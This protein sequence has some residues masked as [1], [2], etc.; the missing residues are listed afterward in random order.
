M[1][2]AVSFVLLAA[3]GASTSRESAPSNTRSADQPTTAKQIFDIRTFVN[4]Q[5]GA[6]RSVWI[7]TSRVESVDTNDPCCG[8]AYDGDKYNDKLASCAIKDDECAPGFAPVY[9]GI[10]DD[11][12]CGERRRCVPL[13]AVRV[14]VAD[15]TPVTALDAVEEE[16]PVGGPD[17]AHRQ[18]EIGRE[19]FVV[20]KVGGREERVAVD[21]GSRYTIVVAGGRIDRVTHD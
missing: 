9:P 10:A 17:V 12:V 14:V 16:V 13:P 15:G 3:C 20:V 8:L 1:K 6:E 5:T 7:E 21:Y 4:E 18:I 2:L 19:G 11:Q